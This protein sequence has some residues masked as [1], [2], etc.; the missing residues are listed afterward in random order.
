MWAAAKSGQ[1]VTSLLQQQTIYRAGGGGGVFS[2][3]SEGIVSGLNPIT[4]IPA[5]DGYKRRIFSPILE[6]A[7]LF[8]NHFFLIYYFIF[9]L[10]FLK[11]LFEIERKTFKT[12]SI[13][14]YQQQKRSQQSH[15]P[16][17]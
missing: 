14:Q 1:Q 9:F 13:H 12:Q 16:L 15:Y 6:A 8:F 17:W 7:R 2:A 3:G 4:V 5:K 11:K 10:S